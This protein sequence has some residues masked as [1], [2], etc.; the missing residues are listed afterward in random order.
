M[1]PGPLKLG[2][3]WRQVDCRQNRRQSRLSSIRLTLLPIWST[4]SPECRTSFRL[5]RQCVPG[6]SDTVDFQQRRPCRFGPVHTGYK[7]DRIGNKVERIRQQ[8]CFCRFVAG[9][10]NSQL[11]TKSTVLNSTLSPVCTRLKRQEPQLLRDSL[12]YKTSGTGWSAKS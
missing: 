9:S 2:T 8:I 3:H 6:Q 10:G 11:S 5:C 12:R 7:V 4:L 1:R